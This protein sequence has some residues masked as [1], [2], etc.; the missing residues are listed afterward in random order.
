MLKELID[1]VRRNHALEHATV[2]VLLSRLGPTFRVVG[3]A[4]RDGFYLYGDLPTDEVA[5]ASAEALRRLQ[6]GEDYLA[7]SPLCGTNI[8]VGG[9]LAGISA[10]LALGANPPQRLDR[11]PNVCM[12]AMLGIIAAQ[13]IG[14]LVQKH[15]TTDPDLSGMTILGV[16]EHGRGPAR[17]HKVQTGRI[18]V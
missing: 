1:A 17:Y 8:A 10:L 5:A 14:R 18:S 16:K 4:T 13:P 9:I 3:R 6:R 15:L 11:L 12:A 2:S 7:I